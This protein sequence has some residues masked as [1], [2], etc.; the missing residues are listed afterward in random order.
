M[1][2]D[3]NYI[4]RTWTKSYARNQ[5]AKNMP[6]EPDKHNLLGFSDVEAEHPKSYIRMLWLVAENDRVEYPKFLD[7]KKK[8]KK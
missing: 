2:L 6:A 8:R 5:S 3:S 1:P 4:L 7:L